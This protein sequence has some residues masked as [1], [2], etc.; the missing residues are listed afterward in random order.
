MKNNDYSTQ[1]S[2]YINAVR[3]YLKQKFGAIAPEW[4]QPLVI[5]ADNLEV[6][7]RCRQSINDDGLMLLA[8]NGAMTKNPLIKVQQDT[9]T[10]IVKLLCEFGLTPKS[11]AK[12]NLQADDEDTLKELLGD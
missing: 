7:Q 3:K 2:K 5:L 10:Q 11:A 8:K 12:M 9:Q 1:T 4:E 6:Y